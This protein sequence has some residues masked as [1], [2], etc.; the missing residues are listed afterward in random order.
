MHASTGTATV[1]DQKILFDHTYVS[2]DNDLFCM[3]SGCGYLS[4]AYSQRAAQAEVCSLP[5]R[6]HC[7]SEI[8]ALARTSFTNLFASH[9]LVPGKRAPQQIETRHCLAV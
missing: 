2:G 3:S 6:F 9:Y 4:A 7:A 8:S 1:G 5:R